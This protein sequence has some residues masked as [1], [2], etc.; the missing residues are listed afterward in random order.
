MPGQLH[1]LVV[2]P[3]LLWVHC[4]H[5]VLGW[6]LLCFD[7]N[8]AIHMEALAYGVVVLAYVVMVLSPW[9][10]DSTCRIVNSVTVFHVDVMQHLELGALLHTTCM[11][12]DHV[13]CMCAI[14]WL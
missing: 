3:A 2:T 9:H 10:S 5:D 7:L 12:L 11:C 8:P 14:T 1:M 4:L 13:A 6:Y